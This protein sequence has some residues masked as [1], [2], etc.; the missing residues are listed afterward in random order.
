[1]QPDPDTTS[2]AAAE[3]SKQDEVAGSLLPKGYEK[4]TANERSLMAKMDER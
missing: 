3:K 1:M 2:T 4:L